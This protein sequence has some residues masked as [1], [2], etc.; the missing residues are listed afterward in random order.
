M[1]TLYDIGNPVPGFG[2]AHKCGRVHFRPKKCRKVKIC[3]Y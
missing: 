3:F 1:T 2:Q